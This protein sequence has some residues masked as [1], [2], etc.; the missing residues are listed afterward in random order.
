M[1]ADEL[2]REMRLIVPAVI[3][4]Y[5]STS[6]THHLIYSCYLYNSHRQLFR[7]EMPNIEPK[8]NDPLIWN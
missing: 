2:L 6:T 4:I 8:F 1:D 3:Y 7:R 5:M